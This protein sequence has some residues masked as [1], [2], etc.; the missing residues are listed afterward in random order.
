MATEIIELEKLKSNYVTLGAV[1]DTVRI[2]GDWKGDRLVFKEHH[3]KRIIFDGCRIESTR[4]EEDRN[5]IAWAGGVQNCT[6]ESKGAKLV[7]GGMVFWGAMVN[8]V[9]TGFE[10]QYANIAFHA[11]QPNYNENV[12][13]CHNV[14]KYCMREA[15]YIGP[16]TAQE[17]PSRQIVIEYNKIEGA[18]WDAIQINA[19]RGYVRHNEI[20]G[21][22]IAG[23][24][25]QNY[26]I[27]IQPGS[28]V[29]YHDNNIQ[30]CD[31]RKVQILDSR[32]F[33][34]SKY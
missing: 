5:A 16:H 19:R 14:V 11:A 28:E 34:T 25:W 33:E 8:S 6:I 23:E 20:L 18:G 10:S 1:A 7:Y 26:G 4:I 27:T 29:F 13:F 15:F 9:I 2:V 30:G 17:N 12:R 31:G 21:A 24:R 3:G 32:A 22:G